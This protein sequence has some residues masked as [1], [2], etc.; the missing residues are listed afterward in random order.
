M[1]DII[2]SIPAATQNITHIVITLELE[3]P[4]KASEGV[5]ICKTSKVEQFAIIISSIVHNPKDGFKYLKVKRRFSKYILK[6]TLN[7]TL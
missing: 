6:G 4:S 1:Y 7:Q 2:C 5:M 3:N